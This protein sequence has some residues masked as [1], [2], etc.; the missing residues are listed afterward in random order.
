VC[1]AYGEHHSIFVFWRVDSSFQGSGYALPPEYP[2]YSHSRQEQ[3][4]QTHPTRSMPGMK[5]RPAP[6]PPS[7]G[8]ASSY[9][10]GHP[11]TFSYFKQLMSDTSGTSHQDTYVEHRQRFEQQS[12][13]A[14]VISDP[15][16]PGRTIQDTNHY[17]HRTFRAYTDNQSPT[18]GWP[19]ETFD[20]PSS[21]NMVVK[22]QPATSATMSSAHPFQQYDEWQLPVSQDRALLGQTATLAPYEYLARPPQD[23]GVIA[24]AS[25]DSDW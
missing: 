6:A 11:Q 16:V 19:R 23:P 8:H 1:E 15:D 22:F 21:T 13:A 12:D 2:N 18:P 3:F 5:I 10:D 17:P 9:Y 14:N 20:D 7:R 24:T 25:T 4:P